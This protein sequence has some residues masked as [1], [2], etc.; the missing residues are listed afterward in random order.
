MDMER[1]KFILTSAGQK[2]N[3]IFASFEISPQ[4][5]D[6][7][8]HLDLGNTSWTELRRLISLNYWMEWD[9]SDKYLPPSLK[10]SKRA[11]ADAVS[12]PRNAQQSEFGKCLPGILRKDAAG[13]RVVDYTQTNECLKI[14]FAHASQA[15]HG[16]DDLVQMQ[17]DF[18]RHYTCHADFG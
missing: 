4:G 2:A 5:E 18:T 9:H 16:E 6:F 7:Y 8:C 3:N 1:V 17:I 10:L 12:V 11:F 13:W 15:T 14:T